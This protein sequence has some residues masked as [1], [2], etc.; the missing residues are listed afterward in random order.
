MTDIGSRA[1]KLR[2]PRLGEVLATGVFHT[3][4][5]RFSQLEQGMADLIARGY[6]TT[7][8][9]AAFEVFVEAMLLTDDLLGID[10]VFPS[11][12]VPYE[13]ATEIGLGS[14]DRGADGVC[15][16]GDGRL[17]A[18]QAKFRTGRQHL[19]W[20]ELSTFFGISD[21][22]GIR[23]LV[24]NSGSVAPEAKARRGYVGWDGAYL[25]SLDAGRLERVRQLV[26]SA[27]TGR[28]RKVPQ[29]HQEEAVRDMC[30][31]LGEHDR[32]TALMACGSGKTL[33]SMW[34]A[35]RL[36]SRD[37]LVMVPSIALVRQFLLAWCSDHPWGDSFR[38]LCVCSDE[39]VAGDEIAMHASDLPFP[40]TTSP[41]EV[42]AFLE[43]ACPDR[44]SVVFS[45][46]HSTGVVRDGLP[47]GFCFDLGIFDEAH[48]TAGAAGSAFGVALDDRNIP[49]IKRM[50]MTATK[51][52]LTR[53]AKEAVVATLSMDDASLY[54]PVGHRLTFREAA[55]RKII[56][57]YKVLVSVVTSSDLLPFSAEAFSSET[58]H[59]RDLPEI[60][61]M[62]AVERAAAR[63]GA[64]RIFTFH[65]TIADA[66][67]F[68]DT[69]SPSLQAFM[70]GWSLEHVSGKMRGAERQ[71]VMARFV[72][73]DRGLLSNAKCLTE[74]VDVPAVDMVAF[75]HRKK[76]KTDIVQAT[77]RALRRL[78]GSGKE[79]GYVLVPLFVDEAEGEDIRSA[80][81]RSGY[82][83]VWD[84]LAAMMDQDTDLQDEIDLLS[85]RTLQGQPVSADVTDDFIE[86]ICDGEILDAVKQ[87]V[88]V[89]IV[90]ELGN[91]LGRD[92]DGRTAIYN[93]ARAEV[94]VED[95]RS[96]LRHRFGLELGLEGNV[97]TGGG[98]SFKLSKA[99]GARYEKTTIRFNSIRK[100]TLDNHD[101]LVI[102]SST[103]PEGWVFPTRVLQAF[104]A[105]LPSNKSGDLKWDTLT[106]IGR[107]GDF[108]RYRGESLDVTP[109]RVD[110][111]ALPSSGTMSD[112]DVAGA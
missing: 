94:S 96:V 48:R 109:Y 100:E 20:R 16:M 12:T 67:S 97:L 3:R 18:Y 104:L 81:M 88:A 77:G 65:S 74:G 71:S 5:D 63:V 35:E 45:T 80:V 72:E 106:V 98:T 4:F 83:A 82:E 14:G 91:P 69:R 52:V 28:P 34:V 78:P 13:I 92:E 111:S 103:R 2:H 62:L 7:V 50:F 39:S 79:F 21:Q 60:A 24:T 85:A 9:G 44:V 33:T 90:E 99:D 64:G 58:L 10:E 42:A 31:A 75:L 87:A 66:R 95:V 36:G 61:S 27:D 40:V 37:I 8:A 73:A 108:M 15:R 53:R 105:D 19:T 110:F 56:C 55:D 1:G 51:R 46:Y 89:K 93:P 11:S 86:V 84:V 101:Y 38:Y 70:P 25:D 112:F 57:H 76:S 49:V 30:E 22:A 26:L 47:E 29:E 17:L 23:L 41:G 54:G 43:G 6:A 68:V 102:W 32:A 107:H 59:P